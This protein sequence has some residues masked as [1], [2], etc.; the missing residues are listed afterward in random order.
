MPRLRQV[1]A[2][3]DHYL[4]VRSHPDERNGMLTEGDP[5][6]RRIGL[7]LEPSHVMHAGGTGGLDALLLHRAFGMEQLH[8]APSLGVL[9]YHLP[10]DDRMTLGD[11]PRLAAL[12]EMTSVE[13]VPGEGARTIGM[14]GDTAPCAAAGLQ[15]RLAQLFGAL[16]EVVPPREDEVRRIAVA[17]AMTAA[18]IHEAGRRGAGLF[19][20]GQ[21]RAPAREAVRETGIGAVAVGHARAE[22]WG[23]RALGGL[24]RERWAGLEVVILGDTEAP[25][26]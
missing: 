25:T 6:V 14:I 19:L 10:F 2:H 24:L 7:A 8:L 26:P 22:R 17:G 21:L 12:L 23:L 13:P 9:A 3:L 18:L 16:E 15:E 11:N 1:A 20:T 4:R 5:F